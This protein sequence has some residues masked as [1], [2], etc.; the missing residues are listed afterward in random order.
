[1][2]V[3]D[4]QSHMSM[5]LSDLPHL[6]LQDKL[7]AKEK[8]LRKRIFQLKN[9]VEIRSGRA[10][11]VFLCKQLDKC[12][13]EI[14]LIFNKLLL[15]RE[16]NAFYDYD[17]TWLEIMRFELDTCISDVEEYIESITDQ[18]E[19][20]NSTALPDQITEKAFASTE[21]VAVSNNGSASHNTHATS[22]VRTHEFS[23]PK[24]FLTMPKVDNLL[25]SV[26]SWIDELP[27]SEPQRDLNA[28]DVSSDASHLISKAVAN[29]N[30]P[31]LQIPSFDGTA[32]DW[33]DFVV[34][35]KDL[36]HDRIY[37]TGA[38]RM[39]YLMQCVRGEAR[40]SVQG[41]QLDWTGYVFGLRRL[42]AIFGQKASIVIGHV[43]RVTNGPVIKDNDIRTLSDLYYEITD[44]NN[45]LTRLNYTS[46]LYS[47]NLLG[48]V[49]ERLTP[50]I[51]QKWCEKSFAIRK[52]EEPTLLHFEQWLCDR[53]MVQREYLLVSS[54]ETENNDRSLHDSSSYSKESN[55]P[56][57]HLCKKSHRLN[58]CLFY[59]QKSPSDRLCVVKANQL[60]MICLKRHDDEDCPS[61]IS[62]LFGDCGESHH[63][64]LH[65]ALVLKDL[66]FDHNSKKE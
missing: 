52:F 23:T 65:D 38:Q 56:R 36:V 57:C 4:L 14:E 62:C 39:A 59:L 6:D 13:S 33:I 61:K 2:S 26:D 7:S 15:Q 51:R 16:V 41:L 60:C 21:S 24:D 19:F 35:F 34:Q 49:I 66:G 45:V 18:T 30:L 10:R 55:C 63:T 28:E 17:N 32:T 22:D 20:R 31:Q 54:S 25:Q 43:N 64:T 8:F 53:V 37:L 11:L 58:K 44:C 40:R 29:Q 46:E 27:N 3:S 50:K 5:D 12:F 42:K 1:M 48:R 9:F 47:S